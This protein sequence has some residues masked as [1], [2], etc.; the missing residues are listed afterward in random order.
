MIKLC[1]RACV[2]LFVALGACGVSTVPV[3]GSDVIVSDTGSDPRVDVVVS[4]RVLR[5]VWPLST[6]TVSSQRPTLRW[7]RSPEAPEVTLALTLC[8]DR[9]MSQAC[10][11]Q[12]VTGT[13]ARSAAALAPGV[14]YWAVR[15]AP[16][17]ASSAVWQFRVGHRSAGVDTAWG[18]EGDYNGDGFA[19]VVVSAPYADPMGLRD[20]GSVSVY[21]GG[22]TGVSAT[23]AVV[24]SGAE[25]QHLGGAVASAGDLNGD[26]FADL[27]VGAPLAGVSAPYGRGY[28]RVYYGSAEG[29]SESRRTLLEPVPSE[30]IFEGGFGAALSS[31][32]DVNGDGFGDLVVGQFKRD[33]VGH[34]SLGNVLVFYGSATGITAT[35]AL[36]LRTGEVDDGFGSAVAG[37]GDLNGDGFADL[38]VGSPLTSIGRLGDPSAVPWVGAVR[39]YYGSAAGLVETPARVIRG[40]ERAASLGASV[41]P[42]G[43]L[44]GDGLGDLVLGAPN[45]A[46][47]EPTRAG[48]IKVFYGSLSGIAE[49]PSLVIQGASVGNRAGYTLAN[50]GDLHGDGYGDLVAGSALANNPSTSVVSVFLGSASGVRASPSQQVQSAEPAVMFGRALAVGGDVNGDGLLDLV[51]GAQ[52]TRVGGIESIGTAYLF[53]G[54]ASGVSAAPGMRWQGT[55]FGDYFGSAVAQQRVPSR[56]RGGV[57]CGARGYRRVTRT[58]LTSP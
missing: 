48:S 5:P 19:E 42:A 12:R 40:T 24:F 26:G 39:V 25:Q 34:Q 45:L 15:V 51:V 28:V 52:G 30:G 57:G 54:T 20:A 46:S 44:N 23:A 1:E 8:R 43:D 55:L 7:T 4:D 10:Q 53:A 41:A 47:A 18:T 37:A 31:A 32:G 2:G 13:S 14:W 49:S 50:A 35:P 9:A 21:N 16:M 29:L 17:G 38:V 36:V 33:D 27:V 3:V 56:R 6:S 58:S 11:T 22:A